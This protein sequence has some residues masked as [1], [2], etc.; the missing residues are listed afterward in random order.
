MLHGRKGG[1]CCCLL[2]ICFTVGSGEV[3]CSLL[4]LYT[5]VTG[6]FW[7]MY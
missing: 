3:Q 4:V 6:S 7:G 1:T 2:L 5:S